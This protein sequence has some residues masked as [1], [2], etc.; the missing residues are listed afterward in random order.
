MAIIVNPLLST[1]IPT[2]LTENEKTT[3]FYA[4]EA[5]RGETEYLELARRSGLQVK[6][7]YINESSTLANEV[8]KYGPGIKATTIATIA[9]NAIE[10]EP[11]TDKIF[12]YRKKAIVTI[13]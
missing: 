5:Q 6:K 11:T 12:P 4:A 3:K 7:K 8:A 13:E 2:L 9:R 10:L 1:V